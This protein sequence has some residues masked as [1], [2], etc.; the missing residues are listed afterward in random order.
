M[1]GFKHSESTRERL[2]NL[3]TGRKISEQVREKMSGTITA[4]KF[5]QSQR[6]SASPNSLDHSLQV[7]PQSRSI[8]ASRCI[9]TRS[10]TASKWISKLARS[11]PP[12]AS[13]NSLD[14]GLQVYLQTR[15]ITASKCIQT[16]SITASKCISNLAP[17]RSPSLHDHCLHVHLQT[18]SI[19]A[20][21]CISQLALL[22]SSSSHNHHL[23]VHLQ[24]LTN[25]AS[26]YIFEKRWRVYGDTGVTQVDR[27][28][29]NRYSADPGVYRHHLISSSSYHTM[30]IHTL[31]FPT[32]GLTRSVWDYLNPCNW[33]DPQRQV[34]SYLLTRFLHSSNQ[35]SSFL[36]IQS[37]CRG[38][39]GGVLMV[40]SVPSSC[41]ISPQWPPKWCISKFSQW[42][43]IDTP[44]IM[45][46][47]HLWPDWPYVYIFKD[48]NNACLIMM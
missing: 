28:T 37:G 24:S 43:C 38:K 29:G 21:K 7:H 39:R 10:V 13:P 46:D 12:S 42:A 5:A 2:S 22:R 33:V 20:S 23:Q 48:L 16:C 1:L 26:K 41:I 8:M 25:A 11:Q 9:Q 47:Y 32:F 15:S 17:L 18:R 45:L 44:L 3:Y 6:P 35:K 36:W 19:T 30:K 14:H 27:V 40:G 34:E 4:S 31:S